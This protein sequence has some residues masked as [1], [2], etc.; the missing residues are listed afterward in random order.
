MALNNRGIAYRN[1][2]N[3]DRAIADFN[4][5][6]KVNPG[7]AVAIYNRGTAY[8]DKLDYDR[9]IASFDA[10]DQARSGQRRGAA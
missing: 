5:A 7:Y 2:A 8:Y 4:E 9:A 3:F 1:K 6:I 10:G